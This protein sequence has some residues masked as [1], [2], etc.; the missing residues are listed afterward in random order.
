MIY[1]VVNKA[2]ENNIRVPDFILAIYPSL[3][4]R[5][6]I[7]PSR[8]LSICDFLISTQILKICLSS[9]LGKNSIKNDQII[10]S[11]SETKIFDIQNSL[12]DKNQIR[13]TASFSSLFNQKDFDIKKFKSKKIQKYYSYVLEK[14]SINDLINDDLFTLSS[15]DFDCDGNRIKTNNKDLDVC[16]NKIGWSSQKDRLSKHYHISPVYTPQNIIQKY[17]KSYI[18]V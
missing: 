10:S 4:V 5:P 8:I 13:S 18:I 17:P 7:S 15:S 3:M 2:I 12:N 14:D 6:V 1:G 9:Y 16:F 11:S